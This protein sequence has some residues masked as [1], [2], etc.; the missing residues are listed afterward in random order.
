MPLGSL[1]G[2]ISIARVPRGTRTT[3]TCVNW[4]PTSKPP[5]SVPADDQI[6]AAE[7]NVH[8]LEASLALADWNLSQKRQSCPQA[9]LVYDL[10]YQ[11]GEW[12]AAG[13]PVVALLP[14]ENVK[15]RVFVPEAKVGTR[16]NRV[17][18]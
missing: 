18:V 6:A 10:L 9:G 17:N 13:K 14:P 12:V 2:R 5:T 11:Q 15:V 7:A 1:R 3:I 16:F 8:A 4:K